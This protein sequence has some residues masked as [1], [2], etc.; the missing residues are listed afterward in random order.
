[1][2]VGISLDG[3]VVEILIK[4]RAVM[5]NTIQH[6]LVK[7]S[8]SRLPTSKHP[9]PHLESIFLDRALEYTLNLCILN[10]I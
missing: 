3:L 6:T 4:L 2:V 10:T 9:P 8:M 7:K 5:E 1:M